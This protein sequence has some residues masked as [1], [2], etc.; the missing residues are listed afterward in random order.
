MKK[1]KC[2]TKL[3]ACKL[4]ILP[5]EVQ[6]HT[7]PQWKSSEEWTPLLCCQYEC[8]S[9][10]LAWHTVKASQNPFLGLQTCIKIK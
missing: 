7:E 2:G 9:A 10:P 8:T 3:F 5:S 6:W 4:K 1:I